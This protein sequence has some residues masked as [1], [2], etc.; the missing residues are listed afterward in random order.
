MS[1]VAA[2]DMLE[3][4]MNAFLAAA[5][6]TGVADPQQVVLQC[7]KVQMEI[8]DLSQRVEYKSV[9]LEDELRKVWWI[10]TSRCRGARQSATIILSGFFFNGCV[11]SDVSRRYSKQD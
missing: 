4:Q 8:V 3:Q 5:E 1:A 7:S 9:L 10:S 11:E 6:K 2:V